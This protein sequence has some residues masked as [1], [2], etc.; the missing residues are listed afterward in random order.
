V[1]SRLRAAWSPRTVGG[2]NGKTSVQRERQAAA[3]GEREPEVAR[4]FAQ[5][6]SLL[7]LGGAE[8]GDDQPDAEQSVADVGR[9]VA[10]GTAAVPDFDP[11]HRRPRDDARHR[12]GSRLP[13]EQREDGGRPAPPVR[14]S[15]LPG[16]FGPSLGDEV[17]DLVP[18]AEVAE[19]AM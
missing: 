12:L 7:G 17:V 16:G 15:R 5:L 18:V 1:I 19:Q 3:I 10:D 11:V 2:Q 14:G 6:A 8:R 9:V 13:E 4:L